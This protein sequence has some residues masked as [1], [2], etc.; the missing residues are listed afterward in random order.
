MIDQGVFKN[1][2]AILCERFNRQHSAPIAARY[3]QHLSERMDTEQFRAASLRVFGFNEFFP[4]PE[5]F[6]TKI[7]GTEDAEAL[8]Q[9]ELCLRVMEGERHILDRMSPDGQRIIALL[10]GVD[11]LGQT[12]LDSVPF[13]RKDFLAMF[14]DAKAV[15]DSGQRLIGPEVTPE[16][17]RI[18]K[19]V[20][21][22]AQATE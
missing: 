17:R 10:G 15:T 12:P 5:D 4:T 1:E 3:Y 18:V 8:D 6:V 9:W 7:T 22:A 20:M 14:S 2:W 16:S 19:D 21:K 13:V 11:R